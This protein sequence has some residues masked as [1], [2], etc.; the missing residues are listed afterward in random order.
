MNNGT[1]H[2][3]IIKINPNNILLLYSESNSYI[4][5]VRCKL[6]RLQDAEIL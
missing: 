6:F 4:V 5:L 2:S 3:Q 1:E